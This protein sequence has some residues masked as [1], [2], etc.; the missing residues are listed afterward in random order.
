MAYR[1]QQIPDVYEDD[2]SVF[3]VHSSFIGRIF[4]FNIWQHEK[5]AHE[6]HDLYADCRL[7]HCGDATQ[8]SDYRQGTRGDVKMKWPTDLLWRKEIGGCFSEKFQF[9]SCNNFCNKEIG[10]ICR[11]NIEQNMRWPLT[12]ANVRSLLKCFPLH[13]NDSRHAYREC[14]M[15]YSGG[16][17]VSQVITVNGRKDEYS[18]NR[19][20]PAASWQPANIEECIQEPL[21]RLKNEVYA[22]CTTDNFDETQIVTFLEKLYDLS[23]RHVKLDVKNRSI[24]DISTLIDTM[25]YLV[26]A[27]VNFFL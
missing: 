16:S 3:E 9:D 20:N 13:L 17:S 26:N 19:E 25:F 5:S 14:D 21:L 23:V 8:W 1:D 7:M 24:Y 11:E 18:M 2:A 15:H 27:Q 12:K 22:F 4:N 6:I 10:P